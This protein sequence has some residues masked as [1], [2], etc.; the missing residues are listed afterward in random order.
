MNERKQDLNEALISLAEQNK[1]AI[2]ELIESGKHK[3]EL[4]VRLHIEIAWHGGKTAEDF[5]S[6]IEDAYEYNKI[7]A[8]RLADK[9]VKPF[10]EAV[11]N[12]INA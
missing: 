7:F 2:S 1:L 10:I 4:N 6:R 8:P 12:Y 3:K 11:E 5:K 9:L